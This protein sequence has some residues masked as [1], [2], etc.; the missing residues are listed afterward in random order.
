MPQPLLISVVRTK[1]RKMFMILLIATM[2]NLIYDL[3]EDTR[4]KKK[5]TFS[6][7]LYHLP[8]L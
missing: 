2:S 6:I 5:L 3:G 4:P 1:I 8:V 7:I